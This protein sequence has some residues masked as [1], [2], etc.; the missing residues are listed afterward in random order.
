MEP[1]TTIII[2]VGT[3]VGT[4]V[5]WHYIVDFFQT[6]I[7]PWLRNFSARM[8][9]FLADFIAFADRGIVS[10]RRGVKSL[11]K[12]FKQTVFG[13]KMEATKISADK[14]A[15]K[16]T[17]F[18]RDESGKLIQSIITENVDW[19]DLADPLRSEIIRQN[20][21]TAHMDLKEALEAKFK[22]MAQ[23]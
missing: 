7:I 15:T 14:A 4:I 16:T 18:V 21:A 2:A 11:W 9:D 8:A 1:I 3:L 6:K 17:T 10:I 12:W 5:L 13:R 22:E 19:S 23:K 20:A